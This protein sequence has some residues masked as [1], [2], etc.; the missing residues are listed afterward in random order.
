MK[1]LINLFFCCSVLVG[2]LSSKK[3]TNFEIINSSS[4]YIVDIIVSNGYNTSSIDTLIPNMSKQFTLDFVDVPRND[5][6]YKISYKLNGKEI[7]KNFGYYS[8]GVPTDSMFEI[9]IMQD[10]IVIKELFKH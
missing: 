7:F 8:N 10:T 3:E 1:I 2:C 6:G 9:K 4:Y 5:G